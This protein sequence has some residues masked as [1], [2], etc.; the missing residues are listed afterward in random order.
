M[1]TPESFSVHDLWRPAKGNSLPA[2]QTLDAMARRCGTYWE[3]P[4]L[5]RWTLI[6]YNGRLRTTLGRALL[7]ERRVELNPRLLHEHPTELVPTLVH[8]LAHLVVYRRYGRATPHGIQFR[9]L[10]RAVNLSPKA[11]HD[12]PADKFKSRR[13]RYLYLHRCDKCG[14]TFI[15]RKVYRNYFCSICGP[16]MNWNMFRAPDTPRGRKMLEQGT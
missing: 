16:K 4:N 3:E 6:G 1:T 15:A 13:R 7:E 10:M 11:T 12:L 2:G 14:Q 9:T 5:D 8:E